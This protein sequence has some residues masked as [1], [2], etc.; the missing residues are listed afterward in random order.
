[1]LSGLPVHSVRAAYLCRELSLLR[2]YYLVYVLLL[3][4]HA[5]HYSTMTSCN[6]YHYFVAANR[7]CDTSRF[8]HTAK[9]ETATT[10]CEHS[11]GLAPAIPDGNVL[12]MGSCKRG[13]HA[14][15]FVGLELDSFRL[16][17]NSGILVESKL[18]AA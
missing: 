8:H 16:R 14:V 12:S 11:S 4:G 7:H 17:R 6:W 3:C 1:M 15:A 5:S 18:I 13:R 10:G 2:S 9:H